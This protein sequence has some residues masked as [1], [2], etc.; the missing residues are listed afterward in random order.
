MTPR[1]LA[2]LVAE[3]VATAIATAGLFASLLVIAAFLH[4]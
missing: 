4:G 3:M 1:R 2:V